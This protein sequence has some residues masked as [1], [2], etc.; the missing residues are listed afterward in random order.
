MITTRTIIDLLTDEMEDTEIIFNSLLKVKTETGHVLM[1][2][3]G[4][5]VCPLE[6][7][8]V[9]PAGEGW[10]EIHDHRKHKD[11]ILGALHDRLQLLFTLGKYLNKAVIK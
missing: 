9:R 5:G 2:I 1:E 6:R 4:V 3:S 8:W 7:L 11:Y 10:T